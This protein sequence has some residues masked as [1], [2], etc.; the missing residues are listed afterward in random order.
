MVCSIVEKSPKYVDAMCQ[1]CVVCG[2]FTQICRKYVVVG[3]G[4]R[5]TLLLRRA[6]RAPRAINLSL[7]GINLSLI[8]VCDDGVAK[9]KSTPTRV[10]H[11]HLD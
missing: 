8:D 2:S 6:S 4:V 9:I 3:S 10:M 11:S 7:R 1:K 5:R